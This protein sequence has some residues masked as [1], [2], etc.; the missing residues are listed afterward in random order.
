MA[1]VP[2]RNSLLRTFLTSFSFFHFAK[3]Y[4]GYASQAD[5]S[6]S[7]PGD[8]ANFTKNSFCGFKK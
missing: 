5:G 1:L 8:R 3:E 2:T 4:F 6:G 7:N